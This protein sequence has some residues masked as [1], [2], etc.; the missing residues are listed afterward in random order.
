MSNLDTPFDGKVNLNISYGKLDQPF[1][2]DNV[3][4]TDEKNSKIIKGTTGK[5]NSIMTIKS[6]NGDVTITQ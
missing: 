4:F 1:K 3:T 2:L 5:G 6:R